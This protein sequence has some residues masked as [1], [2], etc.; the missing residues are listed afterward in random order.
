MSNGDEIS[1]CETLLKI[2][3]SS[4]LQVATASL[5]NAQHSGALYDLSYQ[6]IPFLHG[7]PEQVTCPLVQSYIN[8]N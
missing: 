7:T 4:H 6:P 5:N 2:L 1:P 8:H 3:T